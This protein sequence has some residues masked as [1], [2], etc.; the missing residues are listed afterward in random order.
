MNLKWIISILVI[1]ISLPVL[2]HNSLANYAN[3]IQVSYAHLDH[4][5]HYNSGGNRYSWG[6]YS[7]YMALEP[8][9]GVAKE[10]PTAIEFSIQDRH[11]NDVYNV[12]TQVE[13]Y[14]TINGERV[15]VFPW[16][17][18]EIGDFVLYYVF[19]RT[20]SYQI[21]LS[22]LDDNYEDIVQQDGN[23][24]IPNPDIIRTPDPAR[25]FLSTTSDCNC[26]RT[27]FNITIFPSITRLSLFQQLCILL[28]S[29]F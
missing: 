26:D 6:N 4:L 14:E 23:N 11:N 2:I 25:S 7:S 20:G 13:I 12:T 3:V 1:F 17:F 21:V 9:Y 15:H 29:S 18:R 5:P 27:I 28:I 22:I 19:P 8:E 10:K 24:N 16:T